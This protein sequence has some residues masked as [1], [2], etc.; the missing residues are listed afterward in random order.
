MTKDLGRLALREEG[1]NWVAYYA[2]EGTM[3]DAIMLGS[4]RMGIVLAREEHRQAF[5]DLMTSI[6]A[7]LIEDLTGKDVEWQEPRPAPER[8]RSGNA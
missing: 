7:D 8:E 1:E 3:V 4:I 2:L 6:V 5:I